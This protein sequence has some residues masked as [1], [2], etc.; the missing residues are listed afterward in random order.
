MAAPAKHLTDPPPDGH[1][2]PKGAPRAAKVRSIRTI[3]EQARLTA[4]ENVRKRRR[5]NDQYGDSI[6]PD[7]FEVLALLAYVNSDTNTWLPNTH[8]TVKSWILRQYKDQKEKVKQRI[9][10]AKSRIH[11]SCDLWTSPNALA[12]LGVV[13]HYVTE[14]GKLEHHTLG[15]KDIDGEHDG[16]HLAAAIVEVIDDWGFASKL[17]YF[18]MD[19]AGNNDT[20]M[21]CLSLALLRQYDIRYDPTSHRLR[22]QGHILNLA[23]KAFLFVT[24][25]ET[26]ERGETGLYNVTLTQIEAW[27]RK[28]PL[29][30]LH[31][32]VVYIQQS[33]QRCQK[34]MAI[35][36]NR[37]LVRDNDTRWNSWYSM[38]RA[39]LHL[40]DA[41]ENYFKKWGEANCA[42]DEL[43]TEDWATAEKIMSFL[44]KLKM[45][46]KALESSFA[47]LDN[48]LMWRLLCSTLP[49]NGITYMRIGRGSGWH[50]Q[51]SW[52]R[53]FGMNISL[54]SHFHYLSRNRR[55][56]MS[57]C[58]GGTSIYNQHP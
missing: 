16:S 28:G 7:Q 2:L 9:Q 47:T 54:W 51:R 36:Q 22:C 56:R 11:I 20:M 34:F 30:K 23:A 52:W 57:L 37:K 21:T 18:M 35:S 27:R 43:S 53:R 49:T 44:E 4:E 8:Q 29:G 6:D 17:G 32:F 19:N 26:I 38:L 33:V 50:H 39:G 1:G 15:L 14:D 5:L 40:R 42:G 58:D 24:D 45:T 10:S 31:N 41:I 46:T 48:V 3:I 12:I 13:A 55:L 25:K